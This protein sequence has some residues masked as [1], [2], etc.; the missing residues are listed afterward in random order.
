M[1]RVLAQATV[2]IQGQEIKNPLLR[3]DI[4]SLGDLINIGVAFLF[5]LAGVILFLIVIW[6]GFDFLFSQGDPD[7]I[8]G[9]RMKIFSGI[10]GFAL[11][12]IALLLVRILMYIFG[13]NAGI[14]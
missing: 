10:I 4:T 14:I 9:A 11:L 7:K 5:P 1:N 13:L 8:S 3:S 2:N 6:G 12:V